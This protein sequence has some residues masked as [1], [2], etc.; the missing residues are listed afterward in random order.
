MQLLSCVSGGGYTGGALVN[1]WR[2][3]AQAREQADGNARGMSLNWMCVLRGALLV[4]DAAY[5]HVLPS[6][7]AVNTAGTCV[8]SL[9]LCLQVC[10]LR[11]HRER[12][13]PTGVLEHPVAGA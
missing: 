9:G 1:W 12:P 4:G 2:K 5:A 13:Q 10:V 8:R 3:K 11:R 7:C 6:A